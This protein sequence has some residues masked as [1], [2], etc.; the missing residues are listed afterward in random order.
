MAQIRREY[1]EQRELHNYVWR[2][3]GHALT[4]REQALYDA[5]IRALKKLGSSHPFSRH[6]A[7][8]YFD[9]ADVSAVVARG[10]DTYQS[11]CCER[12]LRD[13]AKEIFI[14]RCERCARIVVSPVACV[15][16]WCGH[17]WYERRTEMVAR[18]TTSIYPRANEPGS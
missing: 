16:L 8:H 5:A 1:D 15:C 3:Y 4:E 9:D 2:N 17:K 18:A 7:R 13:Y 12:L 10:L 11:E 14:N 6:T